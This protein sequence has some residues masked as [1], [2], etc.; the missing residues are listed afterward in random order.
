MIATRFTGMRTVEIQSAIEAAAGRKL[1]DDFDAQLLSAT[2]RRF[3]AELQPIPGILET[4]RAL[5]KRKCVA[6]SSRLE[7]VRASL[8]ITGLLGCFEPHLFSAFD[9]PR[10]KPAPDIFLHAAARMG[11]A[12]S[13]CIV[14]EDSPRGVEAAVAAGMPAI[15]FAGARHAT[16]EL[17]RSLIAAGARSVITDMRLL[18][19][20]IA[21]IETATS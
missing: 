19:D 5:K 20:A 3:A 9:V 6:S 8:E 21:E 14:I 15:G 1:P 13:E 18:T 16:P 11:V 12:T 17:G 4:L 2:M 7:R 10:G